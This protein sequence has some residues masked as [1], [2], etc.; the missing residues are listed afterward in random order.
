MKT[1]TRGTFAPIVLTTLIFALSASVFA[2]EPKFEALFDG[3]SLSGFVQRGGNATY[4]VED[5]TIVGTTIPKT[6]NSF[7]CTA[8]NYGDFVLEY[9]FRV[10]GRLNSGVQIRSLSRPDYREGRVHGYQV[11]IDPNLKRNR[12][13]TAGIYDEARRGW[14]NDLA[15]NAAARAAFKPEQWNKIR[16]EAIGD[17]MKTWLNGV[18]A[19]DLVD[20]MTLSGFIGLQVHGIGNRTD[21][22]FRVQ[23]RN[24]RIQELGRHVWE[25]LFNGRDLTGWSALPG[26][27]WVVKDGAIVG[28]S[29]KSE[30]RHGIL[31]SERTFR[32]FT[33][34][35]KFRVV[36]GDSGLYFRVSRAKGAAS[37]KG[38][39]VEIDETAET[40]GLYETGG[41]GWVV[42]L[43]AQTVEKIQKT[44]YKPGEWA[45]LTLSV[46][47][48]RYV[49]HLN[50]IQLH[51]GQDMHVEYKDIETLVRETA[52]ASV[53]AGAIKGPYRWLSEIFPG[54]VRKYWIYVPAQYDPAKPACSMVVQDGLRRA[55]DWALTDA[56]DQLIHS[57]EVPVTI[58]I[59]IDH[60]IV[61][62]PHENAQARFNRS[63]EYDALGDRYARFL[64]EEI[65]PEV[66]KEYN[67]STDPNDR[68]IAGA[69]SGAIC[70][71]NVAWERPDEFR[72]VLST[73][74]TYVSL[75]DGHNFPMLVRKTEP[76]PIRIFLEDGSSDLN[77]FGG[78]WWIANQDMLSS[79]EWAGYDVKH[80]FGDGGHSGD[81]ARAIMLDALRWL[82]RGYPQPIQSGFVS[83]RRMN[84]NVLIHGE[85]WQQ[86]S[87]GHKFTEGPAVN[88]KGEVFFSDVPNSQIFKIGLDDQVVEFARDTG[89]ANGLMFGADGRL[90]A[91]A[92]EKRQIVAY[93]PDG[94]SETILSG[95]RSND[96]VV[97]KSGIFFTDPR[98][99]K[100]HFVD[101]Q[102]NHRVLDEGIERP[103]GIIL[104]PDQT[105]LHVA[106]SAGQ[107]VYSFQVQQDGS[108]AHK[109]RYFHLEIPYGRKDT[110]A[111]GMAVDVDGRLYVATAMGL[112]VCDPVGRVQMILPKPAGAPFMSNVA[113]GGAA[114]DTLYVTCGDKVF[115]R[116]VN[117]KGVRYF[118]GPV[119]PPRPQL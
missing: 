95:V 115:K 2:D 33:V 113:L 7:L 106:D 112:Q 73:I 29:P 84:M 18:A 34:R 59:F 60:G 76:K 43:D 48:S 56:F 40:G 22:P 36:R 110:S 64:L 37:V 81:H 94:S 63:F 12:M 114:L 8:K 30:A 90:Y 87:V 42:K 118:E 88:A 52:P 38:F 15:D 66:S 67:L 25:P 50:G 79:F 102:S 4:H 109:Q 3:K 53:P 20:S 75:R 54:T 35:C 71:F 61:P 51:G 85:P 46:H 49:V 11:E 5:G 41:R 17:S 6:P 116:K 117:A 91:C 93:S 105:L 58:G 39:Q 28:T 98:N 99:R 72:R 69:S 96:L 32:D 111:D 70:A 24:L 104:S 100:V 82:W 31:L 68:S 44:G 80:A 23:W 65:L 21:G 45:A 55:R 119:T 103:N 89:R 83:K 27:E 47:G 77:I 9:E 108:L 13:W 62:A 74:G 86:L 101:F 16:V 14:L 92:N 26:G 107:F 10:D 1:V 57:G 97:T 19:A 78:N